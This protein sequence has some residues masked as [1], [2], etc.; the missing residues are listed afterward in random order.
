MQGDGGNQRVDRGQ[1]DALGTREPE[2]SRRFTIRGES[3]GLEEVP[4]GKIALDLA[5]VASQALQDFG[6]DDSGDCERLG[7]GNHAAEFIAG[8]AW[9]GTEKIDPDRTVDQ[10]QT[11]SLRVAFKSPFQIPLP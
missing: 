6:D 2:N 5:D 9:E 7:V 8:A 1:T 4:H 3:S 11:R 10:N